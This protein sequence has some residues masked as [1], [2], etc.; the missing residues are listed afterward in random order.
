MYSNL[1][2]YL[3]HI[4]DMSLNGLFF[5]LCSHLWRHQ[6]FLSATHENWLLKVSFYKGKLSSSLLLKMGSKG[7]QQQYHLVA[8]QDGSILGPR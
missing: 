5:S 4:F 2:V 6:G 7:W 1:T 3:Y 8:S